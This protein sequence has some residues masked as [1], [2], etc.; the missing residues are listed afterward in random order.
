MLQSLLRKWTLI[1]KLVTAMNQRTPPGLDV[2]VS[3]NSPGC[4]SWSMLKISPAINMKC[5][6][7]SELKSRSVRQK[8]CKQVSFQ[9]SIEKSL[10]F[11]DGL[12][13][14]VLMHIQIE[15]IM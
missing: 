14:L 9:I 13:Q 10:R 5:R 12:L 3:L 6:N 1:H 7:K 15:A 11:S 8:L 2:R 4:I